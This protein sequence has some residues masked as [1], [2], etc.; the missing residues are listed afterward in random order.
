MAN[1]K[2]NNS[3]TPVLIIVGVVIVGLI[4]AWWFYSNSNPTP[5]TNRAIATNINA[6]PTGTP[7]DAPPGAKPPNMSGSEAAL[8]TV[9]EFADY[10]CPTCASTHPI[11]NQIKSIY[12]SRIKFIFR[13]FPLAIPAHDKAYDAAVAAEAAG[14]QGKF[15]EMQNMLF[16]N[17]Q[18]WTA[19]PGYKQTWNEYA[20]KLGI[21][22][23][24][25]Q[26]DMAG[27]GAKSRVDED[28]KRGR[29]LNVNSTPTI[30]VN[31]ISLE[32]KDFN[33]N[34]MKVIIDSEL[35]K[36]SSAAQSPA[37]APEANATSANSSK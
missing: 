12:G 30:F 21:D 33:V 37:K 17:Q 1:Q 24:K 5:N 10:Q 22:V 13:S 34:S 35:A 3:N 16:T 14:M 7:A 29:A 8:V 27:M 25:F 19:D 31:G 36:A 18:S 9:E 6:K 26:S 23:A 28:L 2:Q 20:Q 4:A 32:P 11:M 15:W